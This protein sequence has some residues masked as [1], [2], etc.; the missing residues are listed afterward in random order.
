MQVYSLKINFDLHKQ[1]LADGIPSNLFSIEMNISPVTTVDPEK[2]FIKYESIFTGLPYIKNTVVLEIGGRSMSEPIRKVGIRTLLD[3]HFSKATFAQE[4]IEI[5]V[6]VP[7]RTF[8]EKICLLH[9]E[10]S[11]P[12][13]LVRVERMSRHLYDL[14][15]MMDSKICDNALNDK[16]LFNSIIAHRK[17][18]IAL[19][20]FDY[21]TLSPKKIIILPPQDLMPKWEDDYN[22]MRMMIYS[23]PLSFKE[24][25]NKLS[26]L[27]EKINLLEW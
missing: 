9:E 23:N 8:L 3:Q 2:V 13:E 7:E 5:N 17:T 18:F 14:A 20:D 21:S 6:V 25:I 12:T 24:I 22:R 10:F 1:L 19:K 26:R 27:N 11:K 16:A 15:R 4:S